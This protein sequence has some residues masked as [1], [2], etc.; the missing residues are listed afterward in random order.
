VYSL[1]EPVEREA[2]A[3]AFRALDNLAGCEREAFGLSGAGTDGGEVA[4]DLKPPVRVRLGVLVLLS[5]HVRGVAEDAVVGEQA[6]NRPSFS[7][8]EA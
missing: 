4:D 1:G 3:P 2:V 7:T 6:V 8:R 5:V